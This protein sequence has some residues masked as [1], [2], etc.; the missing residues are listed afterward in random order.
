MS[1][2]IVIPARHASTRYPG[3]P[4]VELRGAAG[5]GLS[6]IRRSWEAA[7]AVAFGAEHR[8]RLHMQLRTQ[9]AQI[10]AAQGFSGAGEKLAVRAQREKKGRESGL[11]LLACCC[12]VA[13]GALPGLRSAP[14]VHPLPA[15]KRA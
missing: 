2:A 8:H 7:Q 11:T 12:R 3:K 5:Q 15:G 1:V 14:F 10:G 4:L 9:L 13:A 6:L